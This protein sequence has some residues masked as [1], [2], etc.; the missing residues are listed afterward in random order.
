MHTEVTL[1]LLGQGVLTLERVVLARQSDSSRVQSPALKGIWACAGVSSAGVGVERDRIAS[2]GVLREAW[3]L[4]LPH[5]VLQASQASAL[6]MATRAKEMGMVP[7]PIRDGRMGEEGS[8]GIVFLP[9]WRLKGNLMQREGVR[10]M[11]FR[12]LP[13]WEP[14]GTQ[15]LRGRGLFVVHSCSPHASN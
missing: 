10:K 8:G 12:P 11:Q 2:N 14:A 13:A 15:A 6:P 1:E 7:F 4:P 5:K 3:T 9:K